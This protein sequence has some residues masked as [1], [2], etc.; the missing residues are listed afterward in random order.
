MPQP[1]PVADI[2]VMWRDAR[3]QLGQGA[4]TSDHCVAWVPMRLASTSA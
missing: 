4:V 2:Q 1:S 3:A